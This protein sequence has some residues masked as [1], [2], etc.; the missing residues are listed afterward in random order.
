M[1]TFLHTS[2]LQS[3]L[4]TWRSQGLRIGFVPTMGNL[5]E[6]HYA[7][8]KKAQATCHEVVVSIFVNPLQFGANEDFAG[9][10]RTLKADLDGLAQMGVGAVFA[11]DEAEIYPRP[12][13]DMSFVEVPGLSDMLCGASRPGHFRGVTTIV[14]KL[15]NIVQPDMAIFGL[16]DFQQFTI[17]KRMVSDLAMSVELV[18]METIREADGLAMSSRNGYLGAAERQQ[19]PLLYQTLQDLRDKIRQGEHDYFEL[20]LLGQEELE[21]AGFRPD[22]VAIRRADNLDVPFADSPG[23]VILAAAWLGK[24]RLIDNIQL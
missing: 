17:I 22:Y 1:Q 4:K 3:Q 16:K 18:G 5:H 19:A 21:N 24:T 2:A 14:N 12:V 8:I 20:E 23:L 6:G 10:P 13:T 9:Y 7:L 15:F 11:P